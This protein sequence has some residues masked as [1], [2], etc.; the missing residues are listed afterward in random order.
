M[1]DKDKKI[2]PFDVEALEKSLNDSA[3]RVSTI[4]VSFLLFGLYLTIA[5][6]NVTHRQLFL[7][8]PIK[9]PVLNIDLPLVGFFFL[10]PVLFV[11]LHAYVLLQVL[12]LARTAVAYNEAVDHN[13]KNDVYNARVRQRLANTL[14]A[15]IF[16]G[17]P[18]ERQGI[19]GALLRAMAWVT[20]AIIPILIFF[21]FQYKFLPHH[22]HYATW[23][24]RILTAIEFCILVLL[25]P[26]VLEPIRDFDWRHIMNKRIV[27]AVTPIFIFFSLFFLS[28]PGEI[29]TNLASLRPS[30]T[31]S[32]EGNSV[33]GHIAGSLIPN[34]FD[35]L[36]LAREHFVDDERLLKIEDNTKAK[37][38]EPYEGERIRILRGRNY[39]CGDFRYTDL[40]RITFDESSFLGAKLDFADLRGVTL[41]GVQLQSA[42][43]KYAQMSGAQI[44]GRLEGAE[45]VGA[46]L[47]GTDLSGSTL[48]GAVFYD[49]R[50][51]GA[52]LDSVY[53]QGA[54]FRLADLRGASLIRSNIQGG[55]F[56]QA[57]LAGANLS[58]AALQAADF[59]GANLEGVMFFGSQL[60]GATFNGSNMMYSLVHSANLWRSSGEGIDCIHRAPR[61]NNPRLEALVDGPRTASEFVERVLVDVPLAKKEHTRERLMSRLVAP[62]TTEGEPTENDLIACA[63][64]AP[65][66][67]DNLHQFYHANQLSG[68]GCRDNS[69][70]GFIIKGIYALWIDRTFSELP[71]LAY[72]LA[73]RFLGLDGNCPATTYLSDGQKDVLR[74]IASGPPPADQVVPSRPAQ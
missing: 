35:R 12:L 20:L 11:I 34:G 54:N 66:L 52:I 57:K 40:R 33:W 58:N 5:A 14:F 18:R 22:H 6:G 26:M 7:E 17:S 38:L 72:R 27:W 42:S 3:T 29:H 50:L 47:F 70:Q 55:V 10:A 19:I 64:K 68:V 43:L 8:D 9:L 24:H 39:D 37:G 13:V 49:A 25:W 21:V 63:A 30:R 15:Q 74:E 67:S 59:D 45:L 60:Q 51:G 36:S 71:H 61:I 69:G 16:A 65:E 4:W 2:D 53:A 46:T 32:C 1:A 41:N 31:V 73:G 56:A 44:R 28:F 48:Q 23:L 62:G